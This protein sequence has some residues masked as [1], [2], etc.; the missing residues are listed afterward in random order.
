MASGKQITRFLV[1]DIRER[2]L[3]HPTTSRHSDGQDSKGGL[4]HVCAVE[5]TI[6][7][8]V[9]LEYGFLILITPLCCLSRQRL[10]ELQSDRG[11]RNG[12]SRCQWQATHQI[13]DEGEAEVYDV[14]A[15]PP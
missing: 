5:T 14:L 10:A 3:K 1:L 6:C 4:G 11:S 9:E 2:A 8:V 13:A 7:L 12:S 15:P